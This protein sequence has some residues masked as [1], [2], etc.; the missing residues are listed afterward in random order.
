MQHRRVEAVARGRLVDQR[1]VFAARFAAR[2]ARA[3]APALVRRLIAARSRAAA[4]EASAGGGRLQRG[5]EV[6]PLEPCARGGARAGARGQPPAATWP[7]VRSAPAAA[8]RAARRRARR[9]RCPRTPLSACALTRGLLRKR[10]DGDLVERVAL[11]AG[12][13]A[14]VLAAVALPEAVE[15]LVLAGGRRE[16]GVALGDLRLALLRARGHARG[17]V[18]RR[19]RGTPGARA[20]RSR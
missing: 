6:S 20:G 14:V 2:A 19:A 3:G 11:A 4:P 13:L 8:A 12:G 1:F 18:P 5:G 15:H 17:A 7:A 16:L 9:R 10:V